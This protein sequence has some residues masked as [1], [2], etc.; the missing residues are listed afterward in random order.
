MRKIG[1]G[2]DWQGGLDIDDV[3]EAAKVADDAGV[4]HMSVSEAWGRDAFTTLAVLARETHSI[5]LGA[6]IVNIFSRS[7]AALA[8]HFTTLDTLS[9]GRAEIGLGASGPQVIEHF[10]GVPFD[11]PL[12]R[13]REYVDIINMVVAGKPLNYEGTIFRLERGFTLVGYESL[14]RQHIPIYLASLT[15]RSVRLAAEVADG[16][17]PIWIPRSRWA[18][19]IGSFREMVKAAGRNPDDVAIRP[20]SYSA[21]VVTD[22]PEAAYQR[23][24]GSAAFYVARMGDFYYDHFSRSGMADEANAVRAAWKEGGAP[25]GAEAMPAEFAHDMMFAGSAEQCVD[26]IEAQ[27]EAGFAVSPVEVG[28]RDPKKRAAIFRTLVG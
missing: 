7:P 15:P 17:L 16:W 22:D 18:E 24:R 28:E 14:V 19:E 9:G 11:R 3:I 23:I 8:Q 2:L 6:A 21:A 27:Q 10:H 13:M 20:N 25:A 12:T 5:V 4:H 26:W 1:I